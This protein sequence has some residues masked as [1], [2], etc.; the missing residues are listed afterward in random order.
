MFSSEKRIIQAPINR[1][2]SS[3]NV[4]ENSSMGSLQCIHVLQ[5]ILGMITSS[6]G[7]KPVPYYYYHMYIKTLV[8]WSVTNSAVCIFFWLVEFSLVLSLHNTGERRRRLKSESQFEMYSMPYYSVGMIKVM[9]KSRVSSWG[10]QENMW[11]LE[12]SWMS[13]I[14]WGGCILTLLST[15]FR[16]SS[17]NSIPLTSHPSELKY[18]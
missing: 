1:K 5:W 9:G 10:C 16:L 18:M 6:Q 8:F 17:S 4:K 2:G 7:I 3:P 12:L 15:S 13:K 14:F 11:L